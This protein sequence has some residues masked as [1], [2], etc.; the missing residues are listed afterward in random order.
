M[1]KINI[2]FCFLAICILLLLTVN[3]NAQ[4]QV[5]KGST[6]KYSVTPVPAIATYNYSWSAT[7]GTS[8]TFGTAAT[9]NDILWDGAAGAYTITVFPIKPVSLC[10][11]NNQTLTITIVDMNLVWATT[12]STECPKTDNQTGD[13]SITANYTGVAGAWSFKYIIDAGAEQTVNVAAGN[14][15]IVN[16]PGFTNAS[17]AA[18]A[19]HTIRLTSITTPDSYTVNYTG[20]EADAATRLY[21]VT[22]NPTPATS[23]IIQL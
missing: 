5:S 6:H 18:T 3:T 2:Q 17:N 11:G 9:S 1:K 16:I 8:S 7:G 19:N 15:S 20:A 23:G 12:S 10:A 13:F 22:V 14:S 21:T 4:V